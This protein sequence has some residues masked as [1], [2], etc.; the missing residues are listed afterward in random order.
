MQLTRKTL[1]GSAL[2][3]LAVLFV[4]VVLISNTLLRGLQLDL[5]ENSLYTLSEGSRKILKNL[6]EPLSLTL[7]FSDT[8]TA[9]S[10]RSDVRNLRVYYERIREL[11]AEMNTVSGGKIRLKTVDP[12]AY[13][14]AEDTAAAAGAQGIPV[15]DNGEKVFLGLVGANATTG[16][17][18]IPFFDP[19]KEAFLEYD[20]VK[21]I[22]D[23]AH[24]QKNVV[25]LLSGLPLAP[26]FDPQ[27]MQMQ[28]GWAV[29]QQLTQLF[30]VKTLAPASMQTLPENMKVLVL[31][32]PKQLPDDALYAIDQFV[33]H[34]GH[35][36]VFVDP[37]SELDNSAN[38]SMPGMPVV[39]S[40]DLPVL[41]KA[42][43]VEYDAN[44]VV[45]DRSLAL[46]VSLSSGAP[47][48]RHAGI[49]HFTKKELPQNDI[50]TANLDSI[51]IGLPGYFKAAKDSAYTLQPMLQSSE[52]AMT[53]TPERIAMIRDPSELLNG[54]AASGERYVLAARLQGKFKTAFPQ[55]TGSGHLAE[56]KDN[57][58]IL[59][60]ADTDM[61]SNR[62]WVQVQNFFGQNIMNTFA[63]NGNFFINAVDNLSGSSELISIR[64]RGVSS[65]PFTLVEDLKL[66]ADDR[67]R[68][69]EQELQHELTE[70]EQKML[71]LQNSKN[72]DQNMMFNQAQQQELENFLR[73]KL[74]IRKELREVRRQLDA[75]INLLGAW[76]KFINIA[77]LPILITLGSLGYVFWQNKRKSN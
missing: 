11:L 72:G 33:M 17:E 22:Y 9:A 10:N 37:Y 68:S 25:G 57:G 29:Y 32:H 40:S 34:G 41:F 6:D 52:Q 13:S 42:W 31:V 5:T 54:F 14:E 35:L 3:L 64:G 23:L 30:D 49:L 70:T 4:A 45:L 76:L 27:T 56:A 67:F 55:R 65:R 53:V 63:D 74:E 61:L 16:Q 71:A 51:N 58:E 39:K 19:S 48:V 50:V 24:P 2:A 1:T 36:L 20:I 59:L 38:E 77:L 47:P 28:K 18:T 12:I 73:R 43:G 75:D 69:K 8:A 46:E 44:Q 26:G 66:A 15:G 21:L 62:L 60:V 7:Y